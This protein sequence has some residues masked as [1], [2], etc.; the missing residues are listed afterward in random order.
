MPAV[1]LAVNNRDRKTKQDLPAGTNTMLGDLMWRP[2]MELCQ[3]PLL[4]IYND[5]NML[6]L[7]LACNLS[8]WR[9]FHDDVHEHPVG[10]KP[11]YDFRLAI[12]R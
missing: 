3:P 2:G 11:N 10:K 6:I 4:R 12:S 7:L 8:D 1:V 9:S 5:S